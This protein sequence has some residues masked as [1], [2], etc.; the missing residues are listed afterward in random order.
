MESESR[1]E[2]ERE[3][4]SKEKSLLENDFADPCP[5][6]GAVLF[7]WEDSCDEC[8]SGE[9]TPT[10]QAK[11]MTDG[12]TVRLATEFAEIRNRL[13]E[14]HEVADDQDQIER[15]E[16]AAQLLK[17]GEK[18]DRHRNGATPEDKLAAHIE[19]TDEC[20]NCGGEIDEGGWCSFSC[21]QEHLG[22]GQ[23]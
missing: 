16:G 19:N 21:M 10:E 23:D 8:D 6:C 1:N 20:P 5:D 17:Q 18:A 4:S 12:G 15:I 14:L 3:Y 11:L 22:G 13:K 9:E 2:T 7:E